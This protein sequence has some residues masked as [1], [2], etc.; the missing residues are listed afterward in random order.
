M[1]FFPLPTLSALVSP[2]QAP[3]VLPAGRCH[4]R[5]PGAGAALS[6]PGPS[7]A[8]SHPQTSLSASLPLS[9]LGDVRLQPPVERRPWGLGL[10]RGV[11]G[12]LGQDPPPLLPTLAAAAGS[13]RD[14]LLQHRYELGEGCWGSWCPLAA[15]FPPPLPAPQTIAPWGGGARRAGKPRSI[16]ARPQ[17]GG[18]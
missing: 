16:P 6:P 2:A 1:G 10:P 4:A 5:S 15:G 9:N 8:P 18:L 17:S 3:S 7:E 14:A 12:E 13:R 11:G